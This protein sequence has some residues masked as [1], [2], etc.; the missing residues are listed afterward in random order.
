LPGPANDEDVEAS[1]L[2][3]LEPVLDDILADY[4]D[5]PVQVLGVFVL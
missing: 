2:T 5:D 4:L 1:V 3:C